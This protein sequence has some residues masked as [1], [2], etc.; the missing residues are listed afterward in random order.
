MENLFSLAIQFDEFKTYYYLVGMLIIGFAGILVIMEILLSLNDIPGDNINYNVYKWTYSKYYVIPIIW[1]IL[2][3]HLFLG[4]IKPIITNNTIS[5]AVVAGI[6]LILFLLGHFTQKPKV[7]RILVSILLMAG[8][9]I[10][11]LIW[12]MNDLEL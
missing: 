1:G 8:A 5:V 3:G 11:H 6:T 4:S 2:A 7:N 10:G 12:S 9:I